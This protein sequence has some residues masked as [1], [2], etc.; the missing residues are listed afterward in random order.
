MKALI[1]DD[2]YVSRKKLEKILEPYAACV[3]VEN[4]PAALEQFD[5]AWARREPFDVICLDISMPGMDGD[6][7]L[8]EIREREKNLEAARRKPA[9]IMMVTAHSDKDT[10]ITAIQA[11]CNDYLVKPYDRQSVLAKFQKQGLKIEPK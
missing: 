10:I 2:E 3:S 1:V 7:V 11:G 6:E 4:G 9:K 8:F 5:R